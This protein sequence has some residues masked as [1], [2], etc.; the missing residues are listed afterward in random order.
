M[1]GKINDSQSQDAENVQKDSDRL[2]QCQW[3]IEW[4]IMFKIRKC[5]VMHIGKGQFQASYSMNSIILD[6][7]KDLGVVIDS[8]LGV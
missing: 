6:Q 1:F 7:E 3:S 5:K 4:Q 8:D 2:I